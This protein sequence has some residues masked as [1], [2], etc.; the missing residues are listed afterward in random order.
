ML[1]KTLIVSDISNHCRFRIF[2]TTLLQIRVGISEIVP[3]FLAKSMP[4]VAFGMPFKFF[5]RND[6]RDVSQIPQIIFPSIF[7]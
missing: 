4:K 1:K 2:S 7:P 6:H 5:P 3:Y